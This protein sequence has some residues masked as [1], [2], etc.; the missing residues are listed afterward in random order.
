MQYSLFEPPK[1]E[2]EKECQKTEVSKEE[3]IELA[4]IAYRVFRDD[5]EEIKDTE[6]GETIYKSKDTE[7]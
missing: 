5:I 3:R 7:K 6:S 1:P 2:E 4:R